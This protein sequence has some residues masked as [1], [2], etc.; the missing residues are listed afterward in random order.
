M[1]ATRI[2][3][4]REAE[5]VLA[6]LSK[7]VDDMRE[8]AWFSDKATRA[9]VLGEYAKFYFGRKGDETWPL[10]MTLQSEGDE[11]SFVTALAFD[12]DGKSYPVATQPGDWSRDRGSGKLWVILD[13]PISR[14]HPELA[15]ALSGAQAATVRFRSDDRSWEWTVP[16]PQLDAL[17]RVYSAWSALIAAEKVAGR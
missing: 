6:T 10:R 7:E 5:R 3:A 12:V 14:R 11:S 1:V 9:L 15:Q 8:A 2:D 4:E 13:M 16:R 17:G